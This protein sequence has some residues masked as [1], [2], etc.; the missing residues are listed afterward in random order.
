MEQLFKEN[1][2]IFQSCEAPSFVIIIEL[3]ITKYNIQEK[4]VNDL[5]GL[6]S[7]FVLFSDKMKMV[8]YNFFFAYFN[9][10][11]VVT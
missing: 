2:T 11:L 10:N 8:T 4:N 7:Y 5:L 1:L 3:K 6:E 9:L